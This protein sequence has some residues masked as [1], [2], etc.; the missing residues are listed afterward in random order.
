MRRVAAL[1]VALVAI[2][3]TTVGCARAKGSKEAFCDQ[4]Q[5][6]PALT[7]ALAG[8]ALGGT[9]TYVDQLKEARAAFGDLQKAAP[10]SIRADVGQIGEVVDDV[11]TAI[12]ENPGNPGAVA[13][14]LRIQMMSSASAAKAALKV[15]NFAVKECGVSIGGAD[16]MPGTFE[17]PGASVPSGMMPAT[18]VAD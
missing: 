13:A 8:Y 5:E 14:Q 10:R 9:E 3:A 1:L 4:L 11:V 16:P 7:T 15:S 18:T 2:A 17:G 6:T 12:E